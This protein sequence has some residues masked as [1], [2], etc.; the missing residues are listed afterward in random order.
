[1][2]YETLITCIRTD[3][4]C[5]TFC[6]SSVQRQFQVVK[7]SSKKNSFLDAQLNPEHALK[8]GYN[9]NFK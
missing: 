4:R 1:M 3:Q 5:G 8:S 6:K 9:S 7:Y 2:D